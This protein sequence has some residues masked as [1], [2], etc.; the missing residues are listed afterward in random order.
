MVYYITAVP[1][2]RYCCIP[3]VDFLEQHPAITAHRADLL[4]FLV[5]LLIN[6]FCPLTSAWRMQRLFI[7][8]SHRPTKKE[9]KHDDDDDDDGMIYRS[10]EINNRSV[11]LCYCRETNGSPRQEEI[12]GPRWRTSIMSYIRPDDLIHVQI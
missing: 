7:F 8:V 10:I 1:Y 2:I 9:E 12:R 3:G 6:F 11:L 5:I 4:Q